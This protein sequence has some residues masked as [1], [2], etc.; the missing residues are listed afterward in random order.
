[1]VWE[2]VAIPWDRMPGMTPSLIAIALA[3]GVVGIA[4]Y[5]VRRFILNGGRSADFDAGA[6]S[7]SWLTEHRTGKHNDRF[8]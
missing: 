1:M 2:W 7:Q 8:S 6:V 3:A 4:A 5:A